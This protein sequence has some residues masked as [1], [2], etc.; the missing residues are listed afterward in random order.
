M[1]LT[2]PQIW[3]WITNLLFFFVLT[4]AF[5]FLIWQKQLFFL[6]KAKIDAE[7]AQAKARIALVEEEL[8]T[9]TSKQAQND[10]LLPFFSSHQQI[11]QFF[12][13][14]AGSSHLKID[15]L[16]LRDGN[17]EHLKIPV[18]I[19]LSGA[20]PGAEAF[21]ERIRQRNFQFQVDRIELSQSP[22]PQESLK[23][24]FTIFIPTL[25]EEIHG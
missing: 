12:A 24:I 8:R 25:S 7:T 6:E 18:E 1:K 17:E 14:S 13:D 9:F 11:Y 15:R 20:Y 23:L 3:G 16:A 2:K 10:N 4:F 22:D 5:F 19:E 21:F